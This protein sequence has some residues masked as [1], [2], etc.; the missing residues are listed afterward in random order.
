MKL[1]FKVLKPKIQ[2][3]IRIYRKITLNK[4][5]KKLKI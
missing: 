3:V 2:L 1:K 5:L 4:I